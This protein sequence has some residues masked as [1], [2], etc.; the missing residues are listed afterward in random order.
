MTDSRNLPSLERENDNLFLLNMRCQSQR[1]QLDI[2]ETNKDILKILEIA[3]KRD[4]TCVIKEETYDLSVSP[5]KT[6][7]DKPED[8]ILC[9]KFKQVQES[10]EKKVLD[11]N[12][13]NE[14][15]DT[16]DELYIET[17]SDIDY[18]QHVRKAKEAALDFK[19]PRLAG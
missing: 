5:Q 17:F 18:E 13:V 15:P 14:E 11:P 4:K 12:T 9:P 8:H 1:L 16:Q 19:K 6:D 2:A 7:L 3:Q 10:I